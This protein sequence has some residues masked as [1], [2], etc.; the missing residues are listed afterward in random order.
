MDLYANLNEEVLLK[1]LEQVLVPTGLLLE[2]RAGYE[3]KI[4]PGIDLDIGKG[5][6]ILN[7][8]GTID[9]DYR[10][11]VCITMVK[12]SNENFVFID[13]K[14]IVKMIIAKHEKLND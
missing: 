4:K 1:P 7:S 5:I 11:E 12:L 14:R 13:G 10:D 2:K 8:P 9:A 3:A 6:T